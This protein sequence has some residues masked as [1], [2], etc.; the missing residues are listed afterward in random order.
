MIKDEI[1]A[2][3]NN[4]KFSMSSSKISLDAMKR[5]SILTIN[6]KHTRSMPILQSIF[7][8]L[9]SSIG[10]L[11]HSFCWGIKNPDAN[12]ESNKNKAETRIELGNKLNQD[13]LICQSKRA[14]S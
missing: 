13:K 5:F 1:S 12:N 9:A 4:Q 14:S 10:V 8:V 11:S 2:V 7:R 6:N 3:V